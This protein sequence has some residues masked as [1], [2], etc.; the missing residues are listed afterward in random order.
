MTSFEVPLTR[1]EAVVRR[2]RQEI[3]AGQLPAGTVLKDAEL[4]ARLGVSITPVREAITQLAAEG[5]VDVAPNRTRKVA[6]LTQKSALELVDVMELLACAG[7]AG[8]V[9]NLTDEHLARLRTR[10]TEYTGALARGDVTT[11]SAAGADFSTIV[12]MANGNRELQSMLDLVVVR[13]LRMLAMESHSDSWRPW[14]EGYGEVL[15]LLERG[16]RAGA[17]ARYR[18]IYVEFR[19]AVERSL[20]PGEAGDA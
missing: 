17:V 14:V 15:E 18:R 19:A 20:W 3:T 6:G 10:Y 16:D 5:L 11:A 8:G 7:F 1:R 2:L 4:A 13:V 12:V 9:D